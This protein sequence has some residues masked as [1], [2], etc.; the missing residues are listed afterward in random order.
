MKCLPIKERLYQIL[1]LINELT[2]SIATILLHS[3][4]DLS[5]CENPDFPRSECIQGR[6]NIGWTF[7]G[8]VAFYMIINVFFILRGIYIEVKTKITAKI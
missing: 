8:V 5:P 6:D 4:T 7:I 3:F 2:L 1:E